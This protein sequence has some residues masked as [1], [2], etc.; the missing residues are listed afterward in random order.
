MTLARQ[1]IRKRAAAVLRAKVPAFLGRVYTNRVHPLQHDQ[2]PAA[3]VYTEGESLTVLSE[4]PLEHRRAL[5]LVVS[6][7]VDAI[8]GVDDKLDVICE[9]V[10][11]AIYRD[12]NLN[13]TAADITL[14]SIEG[15]KLDADGERMTGEVRLVWECLYESRVTEYEEPL[16]DLERVHAEF[17][18]HEPRA[19]A[20]LSA[21]IELEVATP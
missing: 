17:E 3:V 10:E 11:S 19:G 12:D 1:A 9:A 5:R 4:A 6:V 8:D 2:L 7:I 20:E 18:T 15:P 16:E 13:G 14:T 21:D